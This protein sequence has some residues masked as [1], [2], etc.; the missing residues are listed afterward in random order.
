M[1]N[2][3]WR[4]R[5]IL[6][7]ADYLREDSVNAIRRMLGFH[8]ALMAFFLIGYLV[9]LVALASR[10]EFVG[11]FFTSVIFLCG[12][13]FVHIGISIQK[14][15]I[16]ELESTLHGLLPICASCKRIRFAG[17][18]PQAQ[19]SW[20]SVEK[21]LTQTTKVQFSHGICPECMTKLYPEID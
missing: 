21:Y 7:S 19:N 18:D 16:L 10:M 11:E 20:E 8:R 1:A 4:T 2:C 12:A 3:L 5:G 13:V 6:R 15:M 17:A 9:V 14:R